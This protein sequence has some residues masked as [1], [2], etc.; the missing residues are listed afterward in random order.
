MFDEPFVKFPAACTVSVTA[1]PAVVRALTSKLTGADVNVATTSGSASLKVMVHVPI[2][3]LARALTFTC[4]LMLPVLSAYTDE[5]I[6]NTP[7]RAAIQL[8]T[9]FFMTL[10]LHSITVRPGGR[11][12][13]FRFQIPAG[14]LSAVGGDSTDWPS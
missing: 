9:A 1:P 3:S 11:G 13:R 8:Q 6:T 4:T 10:P 12:A 7:K 14:V 5:D 2:A